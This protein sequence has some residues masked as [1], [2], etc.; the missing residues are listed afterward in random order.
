MARRRI[1]RAVAV[2]PALALVAAVAGCGSDG[3]EAKG[4]PLVREG[5]LT[6]CT[7]PPYEPFESNKDGEIVGF[8]MDLVDLVAEDLGVPQEVTTAPFESIQSGQALNVGNCDIAASAITITDVREKNFDFSEPYFEA[9]QA[10]L[11]PKDSGVEELEQLEG[12]TVGY[13]KGTTGEQYARE[14][15]E[16]MGITVKQYADLGLLLPALENGQID[17]VIS[18]DFVLRDYEKKNSDFAVVQEFDTGEVYGFGV[19]TGNDKLRNKINEVLARA[20]EDGTYDRLYEKWF[21]TAPPE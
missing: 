1:S 8:D 20:K 5:Q 6:T 19:K 18:D 9:T 21:G 3:G 10:L 13:Q 12:K 17:A 14:H 4:V 2:L 16:P 11:V 7:N 15:A